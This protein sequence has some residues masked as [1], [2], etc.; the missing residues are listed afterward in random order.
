MKKFCT[1]EGTESRYTIRNTLD[2]NGVPERM[3]CTLVE[4]TRALLLESDL[5]SS[6]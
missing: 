1:S 4:K 2:L 3:N 6:F 5:P